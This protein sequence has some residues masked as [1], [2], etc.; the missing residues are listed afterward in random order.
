MAKQ[1]KK[2]WIWLIVAAVVI[3]GAVFGLLSLDKAGKDAAAALIVPDLTYTVEPGTLE[4]TITA[5]GMLEA[6]ETK[7][8]TLP[9]GL[10]VEKL[11]AVAGDSVKKG[12]PLARLGEESIRT[13]LL[14]VDAKLTA[15][16]KKLGKGNDAGNITSPVEGRLKY[17]VA[18]S[19]DS[20]VALMKDPGYLALL[21]TD[22]KMKL[23]VETSETLT[24]GQR[25]VVTFEGGRAW[26]SVVHATEGGYLLTLPDDRAP[27]GGKAEVYDGDKLLGSGTLDI[28]M[29]VKVTGDAGVI[30][31]VGY[32]INEGVARGKNMYSIKNAEIENTY[33]KKYYERNA[34]SDRL[35]QLILLAADPVV[36]APYDCIVVEALATEGTYTGKA[37]K[38]D[39]DS[40][41]FKL[42]VGGATKLVVS[43]DELDIGKV[44]A[45]QTADV[46]F[47][48]YD[49]ETFTGT[50]SRI[51]KVGKKQNSIST[52]SVE[53]TL[54]EDEKLLAGMNATATV[55]V[56]RVENVL[57]V[58]ITAVEED[59]EGQYVF[60]LDAAGQKQRTAVTTGR[61]DETYV[62]I[63]SGLEQGDVLSYADT[64]M[65]DALAG[66]A[67]TV[68]VSASE[69]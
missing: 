60:V 9:D 46:A 13:Q 16:D 14:Y 12:E 19:G 7:L 62:E 40:D 59:T 58:P 33:Q 61:A 53:I 35:N 51:G 6:T 3:G 27:Y 22:G 4:T 15:L 38:C 41:A 57:I 32:K 25:Y 29:P 28:N 69:E 10:L 44:A 17:Q 43:V 5:S 2:W 64:S 63:T 47:S 49:T 67:D 56:E 23:E 31:K 34:V 65:E 21:S 20:V 55:L 48:A 45:G 54:P 26:G 36:Y 39:K 68:A 18:K 42:N 50:V 11:I 1:K 37:E 52:Y 30:D 66:L 24:P 8:L